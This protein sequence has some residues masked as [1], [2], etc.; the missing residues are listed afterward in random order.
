MC[1]IAG[2]AGGFHEGL[3][4]RMNEAQAHRGPDGRGV[5]E[6]EKEEIALA[7]VRLSILDLS[8][9]ARQP[10]TSESGRFVLSYNGEIYNFAELRAELESRGARFRSSGDTEVLLECLIREGAAAIPKLNGMFAFAL[11]DREE[12]TLLLGRDRMGIKPLYYS[13]LPGGALVFASEI[14]ALLPCPAFVR[15]P[16]FEALIQHLGFCHASGE[17]TALKGVKR[18]P[19]GHTLT[20]NSGNRTAEVKPFWAPSYEVGFAGCSAPEIAEELRGELRA[21][22]SRQMVADV[23]VGAF[24]SGGIDSSLIVREAATGRKFSSFTITYQRS[25]NRLD[26]IL[27]DAPY[28]RRMA[29][30]CGSELVEV[31]VNADVANLLPKLIWHLDEPISDPAAITCYLI[32][33]LARSGEMK[34]L[35]SGQGADELFAGYPRY[36]AL[37]AMSGLRKLPRPVRSLASGVARLFPG[38]LPGKAGMWSRRVRRIVRE[39]NQDPVDQFLRYCMASPAHS[40]AE[41]LSPEV[42][43]GVGAVDPVAECRTWIGE[44][45]LDGMNRFLDRDLGVYLPNHNLLYTDKMG[46][47]V[48]L[49]TRVPLID[50]ELVD[51]AL[52]LPLASKIKGARTKV[53]LREA[54]RGLILDDIIDRPKAGFGAP[55][56]KWLKHDLEELWNDVMNRE[57]VERR[58]WFDYEG[59][60]RARRRSLS[61]AVDLYM[62]QWAALSSELWAR[63]FLDH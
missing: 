7:H 12:R 32:S 61:G 27:E 19:P 11:W 34:V 57:A 28:A 54:A 55:F 3:A 44:R 59:L 20:W 14:K 50:N 38:G 45:G 62:L 42:R 63:E 4:V 36:Q 15:E 53:A 25:E 39:A 17:R 51:L 24:L 33:E 2:L 16:D 43:E 47:A 23:P 10:M 29:E 31:E 37:N 21:A 26:Q 9:A 8:D 49:E 18:L 22:V 41:I 48:G 58:G 30:T 1:G 46:M 60:S 6:S 13:E 5:F 52:R 56:R 40:I 35:L